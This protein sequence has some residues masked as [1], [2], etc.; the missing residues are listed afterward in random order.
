MKTVVLLSGGVDSTVL[1]AHHLDKGN[2]VSAV[3][4]DYGQTHAKELRAAHLIAQH[5][6]IPF[7]V[8]MLEGLSGSAL[9]GEALIP[10]GHADTLDT[11]Y[12][13][14]RNL[15]MLATAIALAEQ[16]G[17]TNVSFGANA[18]DFGGYPDCRPDFI[19]HIDMAATVSAKVS[20]T[21]PFQAWTKRQVI[22]HGRELDAPLHLSWSCY[23]GEDIPCGMCGAC[24]SLQGAECA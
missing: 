7:R 6:E 18:D 23:R 12:V 19:H 14:G 21:A 20:V 17:A 10:D 24:V 15:V 5:Y 13:P 3:G 22:T 8:I 4:F 16:I 11:T 9:T 1:T 2:Q